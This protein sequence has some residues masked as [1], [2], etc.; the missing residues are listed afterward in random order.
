VVGCF[1]F[2]GAV[3]FGRWQRARSPP[4]LP[5]GIFGFLTLVLP[6]ITDQDACARTIA[7]SY[8]NDGQ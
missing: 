7:P 2:S 4:W 8:W 1:A 5:E 3:H 6:Q